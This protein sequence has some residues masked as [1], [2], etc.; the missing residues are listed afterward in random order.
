MKTMWAPWRMDYIRSLDGAEHGERHLITGKRQR[1]AVEDLLLD[2]AIE[3]G[4]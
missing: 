3:D 4:L 2:E 1:L